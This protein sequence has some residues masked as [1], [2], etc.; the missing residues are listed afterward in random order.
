MN[1]NE[2]WKFNLHLW[3]TIHFSHN[4]IY[5]RAS[6]RQNLVN[7]NYPTKRHFIQQFY[8][9]LYSICRVTSR[10]K[11]IQWSAFGWKPS[12]WFHIQLKFRKIKHVLWCAQIQ[13]NAILLLRNFR[14]KSSF[15]FT[16]FPYYLCTEKIP[17]GNFSNPYREHFIPSLLIYILKI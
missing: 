5:T 2:K 6:V 7:M 8:V 17:K 4:E 16:T 10:Y 15:L 13:R 3:H 12:Q 1:H 9:K 14:Q 11:V